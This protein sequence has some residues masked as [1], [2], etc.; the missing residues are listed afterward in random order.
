MKLQ[1]GIW[2][3]NIQVSFDVIIMLQPIAGFGNKPLTLQE[4]E[5]ADDGRDYNNN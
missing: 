5:F 2:K 3:K 1:D 4:M